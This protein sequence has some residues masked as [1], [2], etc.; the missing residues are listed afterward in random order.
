MSESKKHLT[1]GPDGLWRDDNGT[2]WALAEESAS[3]DQETRCGIGILS[4]PGGV[5]NCGAHDYA[6]SSPKYQES[7]TR[8][9]ADQMLRKQNPGL[10]GE[11]F[12]RL[13]RWFGGRFWENERTR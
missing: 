9:E 3:V 5:G 6:Y 12:Y 8:E 4:L 13:S 2:I 10:L 11:I 7:H 1:Q